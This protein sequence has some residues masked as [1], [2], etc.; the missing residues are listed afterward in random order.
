MTFPVAGPAGA[1]IDV[2]ERRVTLRSNPASSRVVCFVG[3]GNCGPDDPDWQLIESLHRELRGFYRQGTARFEEFFKQRGRYAVDPG[4]A[5]LKSIVAAAEALSEENPGR[6]DPPSLRGA[7]GRL[8]ERLE[9]NR[10]LRRVD[11]KRWEPVPG[12]FGKYY[13]RALSQ[14]SRCSARVR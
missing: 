5:V 8:D 3:T 10:Q 7:I 2:T 12:N 14:G 4:T 11:F 1:L 13:R 6:D 9:Q